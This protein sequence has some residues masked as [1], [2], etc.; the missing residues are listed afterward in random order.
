MS[1]RLA[2]LSSMSGERAGKGRVVGGAFVVNVVGLK[3]RPRKFLQQIIL[4]VGGAVGADDADGGCRRPSG[5]ANF[6]QLACRRNA[7][8]APRWLAPACPEHCAPAVGQPLGALD[9]VKSEAALGAE[10]VAIDA[11]L[12]AIVGAH[13]FGAV[14]RLAHAQRHLAAVGAMRA[15]RRHVIHLPRPRLVAIAAAGKRAHGANVDAHAA[16][17]AIELT[18]LAVARNIVRH[19]HR[20]DAAILHAERPHIHAFA[21][22][23]DAA[24]TENAARAVVDRLRAT[25]AAHRG[26][27]WPR[28]KG[29]RPR[30]I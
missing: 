15:N 13:N 17:L 4:F 12:V 2:V 10:K 7:A 9:K 22:H 25:T 18:G 27:A 20:A 30:R 19:N 11:A 14:V 6:F 23:A 29:S 1:R 28:R 16:L 5:I 3:N 26:A 21:A 8:H 24:V